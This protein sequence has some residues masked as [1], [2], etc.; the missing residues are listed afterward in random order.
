MKKYC[1]DTSGISNP[2]ETMPEDIHESLW[3]KFSDE[4]KNGCIAVTK[5][6]YG[7][8][9]HIPGKIGKCIVDNEDLMVLEVGDNSW[10]WQSY[11]DHSVRMQDAYKNFISEY[12][13]G[14]KKTIGLID[15]TIIAMAKALD[16]PVV[17]ME[18]R[19]ADKSSTKRRIP[20]ICDAEQVQ[21]L[22][23]NDYLRA[24]SLRF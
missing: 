10:D 8:M 12:T 1:F 3:E 15:I 18:V 17:S 20:D 16:L 13:G 11:I 23:F 14:S 4:I 21:H 22:F 9:I 2:A 19:V 24:K 7:E 6:I 5:E